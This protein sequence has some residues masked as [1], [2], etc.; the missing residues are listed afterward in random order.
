MS[1]A[2]VGGAGQAAAAD[3]PK[4]GTY[5]ITSCWAGSGN[6]INFSQTHS[7]VSYEIVG[8]TRSNPPGG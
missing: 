6:F 8:T 3:L 5:D 2:L 4:E 1:A 7:A